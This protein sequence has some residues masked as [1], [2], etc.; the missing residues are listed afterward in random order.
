M[1]LSYL[2][3]TMLSKIYYEGAVST[4]DLCPFSS[5]ILR[6]PESRI[7]TARGGEFYWCHYLFV[8]LAGYRFSLTW[9]Q[10][11]GGE[12]ELMYHV[13]SL[14]TLERVAVDW[15]KEDMMFSTAMCHVFF[16]RVS[17]VV[18]RCWLDTVE[19]GIGKESLCSSHIPG[20][21]RFQSK[22]P[23]WFKTGEGSTGSV[24][25]TSSATPQDSL[26]CENV[27]SNVFI[28]IFLGFV[29]VFIN[30]PSS[31]VASGFILWSVRFVDECRVLCSTSQIEP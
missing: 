28:H 13:S 4:S 3:L 9:I 26:S 8:L 6:H 18:G 5:S 25:V 21:I 24:S 7:S 17:R 19:P 11:E 20:L 1:Y 29:I 10:H 23:P 15:M 22:T 16:E 30:Y 2:H 31:A 12:G 14:G 27:L